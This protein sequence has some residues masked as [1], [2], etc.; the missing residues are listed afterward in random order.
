MIV[1]FVSRAGMQYSVISVY[2]I[3]NHIVQTV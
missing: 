3:D 1:I 2:L